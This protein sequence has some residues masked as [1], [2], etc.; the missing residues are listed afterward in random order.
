MQI[1]PRDARSIYVAGS[2]QDSAWG[3]FATQ[4]GGDHW[5]TMSGQTDYP[6][7]EMKL[8]KVGS[9]YSLYAATMNGLRYV[10]N[11][12]VDP[13]IRWERGEGISETA[14]IDGLGAG[15]EEGRTVLYIGT[16][17]GSVAVE[18]ANDAGV[19]VAGPERA[20]SL[21]ILAGGVYRNMLQEHK[22]FLP[23]VRR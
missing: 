4:D 23:A 9:G 11:I 8:V 5:T 7:W 21:T 13:A 16:S 17:G 14:T 15:A 12:P 1:D 2:T 6:I 10:R 18:P 19:E 20:G 3:V 22:V